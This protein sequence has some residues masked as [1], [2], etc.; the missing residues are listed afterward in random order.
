MGNSFVISSGHALNVRGAAG[1]LDEVNEARKVVEKVAEYLRQLAVTV[2]VFH[3]NTSSTQDKNLSTI[4]AFHN[5][6][7]REIDVSIHFNGGAATDDPRGVEV[8]Y[9]DAKALADSISAA[10]ANASGLKNRGGKQNKGLRFL[11]GTNRP[12]ILIEVCFVNSRHDANIYGQKFDEICKA[13]AESLSGRKVVNQ[14]DPQPAPQPSA[15]STQRRIRIVNVNAAAIMMNKPDRINA[16]NIDTI[17]KNTVV[18]M[19]VPV[20]GYNNG[21]TGYYKIIYNGKTGYIN[22]KYGQEV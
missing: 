9:Y 16:A 13:I 8:Y 15:P 6:K 22:A 11:N 21:T 18:D 12:A 5:G 19:I 14:P 10:I 7:V 2:H 20:A 1:F 4:V 3:D 17:P